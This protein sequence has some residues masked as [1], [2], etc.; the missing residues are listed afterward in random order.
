ML[1][2]DIFK[3]TQHKWKTA[4]LGQVITAPYIIFW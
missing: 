3:V 1:K 4:E 2:Q